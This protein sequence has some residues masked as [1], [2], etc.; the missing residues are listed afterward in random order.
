MMNITTTTGLIGVGMAMVILLLL[1]RDHIF[2]LQ[3]LFWMTA[4]MPKSQ[5]EITL[6]QTVGRLEHL[7]NTNHCLRFAF[8]R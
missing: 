8:I 7:V 2:I 4:A 5:P 6:D 1:R 3:A